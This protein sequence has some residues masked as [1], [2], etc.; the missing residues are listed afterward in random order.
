MA[1]NVKISA[2]TPLA[3]ASLATGD[4]FA[5]AH[6]GASDSITAGALATG[7]SPLLPNMVGDV[8]GPQGTT[9]VAT[10]GG[11]TA[12][13][14]HTSQLATAAA[15]AAAMPS[16]LMA[17]DSSGNVAVVRLASASATPGN[18]SGVSAVTTSTIAAADVKAALNALCTALGITTA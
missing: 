5:V 10:V 6:S 12:A 16:T 1:T 13:N 4:Q 8:T 15:T 17:R 7:L 9:V 18:F 2:M 11:S 3:G 14:I